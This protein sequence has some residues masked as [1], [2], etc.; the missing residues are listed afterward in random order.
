MRNGQLCLIRTN[1]TEVYDAQFSSASKFSSPI[2]FPV[3]RRNAMNK[4]HPML[5]DSGC[6]ASP[7]FNTI[8]I[9]SPI[10]P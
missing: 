8:Y 1:N 3:C 5:S 7:Q 6:F 2:L 10:A 4:R 9:S